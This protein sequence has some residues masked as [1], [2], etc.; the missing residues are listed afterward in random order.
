MRIIRQSLSSTEEVRQVIDY[1]K[2]IKHE[3]IAAAFDTESDGLHLIKSRPFLFQFGWYTAS[4]LHA[5]L[6]PLDGSLPHHVLINMWHE[7]VKDV[8]LYL[9][10][11]TKFDLHMLANINIMYRVPNISDTMFYI[12]FCSDNIS[13]RQG[14]TLLSLKPFVKKHINPKADVYDRHVQG[15]RKALASKYNTKLRA[16]L[17]G[18]KTKWE[19]FFKDFTHTV[20]DLSEDIRI[21]YLEFRETLPWTMQE[22]FGFFTQEDIPYNMV[23]KETMYPYAIEDIV[24]VLLLHKYAEPIIETRGTR[25]GLRIENES[26]YNFFDMERVGFRLDQEY[27]QASYYKMRDYII[28]RRQDL[29]DMIGFNVTANQHKILLQHF[30]NKGLPLHATSA[31]ALDRAILDYPNHSCTPAIKVIQELRTLEK[32]FSTYLKRFYGQEK[33]YT[34]VNQVGAASLRVSSDF[35][36]FP[37]GA[38]KDVEGNEIFNPR[39]AI[40]AGKHGS[41]VYIDYSQIEL[42]VQALYTMLLGTPDTNLC[43]AFMPFKSKDVEGILFNPDDVTLRHTFREKDWYLE[44]NPEELW[45][46]TDLHSAT[47][48][49]AFGIDESHP[50]F[51]KLR[52]VGKQVNFA[53]NYG[54]TMTQIRIMF[55]DYDEET[56]KRIDQSYYKAFPEIMKYHDYCERLALAQSYATNLFGIRYWNVSGHNLK[57]MLVQGS[58]ATFLKI[59]TNLVADY[60]RKNNLITKII[61]PIHDEIQLDMPPSEYHHIPHIRDIMQDMDDWPIPIIADVEVTTTNWA[62]KEDMEL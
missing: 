24:D 9:A 22:V 29:I 41:T 2:S 6:I 45:H 19:A 37:K 15:E 40:L 49:V 54:A 4:E 16:I 51:K 33:I 43:R 38:I 8:P 13:A 35:Q 21:K 25:E 50:D 60:I 32:W 23:S 3:V 27:V 17:G 52:G 12:R 1:F 31:D 26:L 18:T 11:N 7:A 5:Y 30:Q 58:S 10:H 14:G 55:P 56:L 42:R 34:Q 53:K 20:D 39:R 47:T 36:Q 28:Q 62:E 57:N 44:E 61:L 48:K 46:P 59:K